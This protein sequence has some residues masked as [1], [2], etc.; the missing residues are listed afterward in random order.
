V[1]FQH[2][3]AECNTTDYRL[4][5]IPSH[6]AGNLSGVTSISRN[7]TVC[8]TSGRV[9]LLFY[10]CSQKIQQDATRYLRRLKFSTIYLKNVLCIIIDM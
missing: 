9:H 7:S 5:T 2:Y 4:P 1:T 6:S 10:I 3:N 8:R